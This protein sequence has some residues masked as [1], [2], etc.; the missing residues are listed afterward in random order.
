MKIK[1]KAAKALVWGLRI[2]AVVLVAGAVVALALTFQDSSVE[3]IISYTPDNLWLAAF[4]I[5]LFYAAI[6]VVFVF[7]V[8]VLYVSVGILFPVPVA[9][10]VNFCG[11]AANIS[12]PF[13]ITKLSGQKPVAKL[14]EKYPKFQYLTKTF[15]KSPWFLSFLLRAVNVFP[16]TGVSIFMGAMGVDYRKYLTGSL[17]G[18]APTMICFTVLGDSVFEPNSP[19]FIGTIAVTLVVSAVSILIY[20]RI[21][22]KKPSRHQQKP[23]D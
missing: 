22:K 23:E 16:L 9:I 12:V 14:S 21:G 6:S 17:C 5:I 19:Q 10:L 8:M 20:W 11:L 2:A 1:Q 18:M 4:F 7:P 15:S 3:D 13:W